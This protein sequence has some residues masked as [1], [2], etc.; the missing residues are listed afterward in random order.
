MGDHN[1]VM[2]K[3][4]I[5]VYH[6]YKTVGVEPSL[7][8]DLHIVVDADAVVEHGHPGIA[9]KLAVGV[10]AWG[11]EEYVVALPGLRR[12]ASVYH[13]RRHSVDGPGFVNARRLPV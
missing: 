12:A 9:H 1:M 4:P 10:V 13:R 3:I 5:G 6:G 7:L 2:L 8:I 11:A